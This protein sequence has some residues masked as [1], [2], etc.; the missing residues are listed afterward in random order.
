MKLFK[1][2]VFLILEALE[3]W[4]SIVWGYLS[5]W[6]HFIQNKKTE[7][8][9]IAYRR[10]ILEFFFF[11]ARKCFLKIT[12]EKCNIVVSYNMHAKD[13]FNVVL[14]SSLNERTAEIKAVYYWNR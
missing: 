6:T 3:I 1:K 13:M 14:M 5:F 11:Q 4:I 10:K 12:L 2:H 8:K 7:T 9:R